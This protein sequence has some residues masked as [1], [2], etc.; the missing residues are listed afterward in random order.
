MLKIKIHYFLGRFSRRQIGDFFF[1]KIGFDIQV[2]TYFLEKISTIFRQFA[3][4]VEA[5]L[6]EK[7]QVVSAEIFTQHHKRSSFIFVK[8]KKKSS[9]SWK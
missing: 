7:N 6:L 3:W 4:N 9:Y 2:K 5:Y 8:K 1:Q